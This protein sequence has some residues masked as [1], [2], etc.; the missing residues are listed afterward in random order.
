MKIVALIALASMFACHEDRQRWRT[1]AA[2]EWLQK[3]NATCQSDWHLCKDTAEL[4]ETF[5]D[6]DQ[7]DLPLKCQVDAIN[8]ARYG[9]L[10][11]S[12]QPFRFVYNNDTSF[13]DTEH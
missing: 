8:R 9:D 5:R 7:C 11:F 4:I 10:K 2:W 12:S 6:G 3:H 13:K 1:K